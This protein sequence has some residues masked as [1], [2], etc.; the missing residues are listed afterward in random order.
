MT[1]EKQ[2]AK[3]LSRKLID[4]PGEDGEDLNKIRGSL[5]M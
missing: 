4:N 1:L 2:K 3:G 5:W